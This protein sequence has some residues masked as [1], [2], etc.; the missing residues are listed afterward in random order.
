MKVLKGLISNCNVYISEV[1]P[2][3]NIHLLESA[4]LY[5]T[6]IL[7]VFGVI[8]DKTVLGFPLDNKPLERSSVTDE[9]YR[10]I[11][12]KKVTA[13]KYACDHI[14]TFCCISRNQ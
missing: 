12:M 10:Q 4:G 11:R 9:V 14:T 13:L 1:G 6:G 3:A 7:K 5:V 8:P 2:S